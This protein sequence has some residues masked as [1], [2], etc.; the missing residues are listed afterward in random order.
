MVTDEESFAAGAAL[1]NEIL[2]AILPVVD[3]KPTEQAIDAIAAALMAA[4]SAGCKDPRM[5]RLVLHRYADRILD[6]A[7]AIDG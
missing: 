3:G 2:Q 1:T 6:F 5:A 4:L 7:D